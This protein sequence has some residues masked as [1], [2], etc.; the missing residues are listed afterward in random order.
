[1]TRHEY[2]V[3]PAPSRADKIKGARTPAD[4]FSA[5]L[6]QVLNDMAREGWDYVRA[7][8]LPSEERSGLTSR[9]TVWNNV[10]I[11]RRALHVEAAVATEAEEPA[12]PRA[13]QPRPA[14]A[15]APAVNPPPVT[16]PAAPPTAPVAPAIRDTA[17]VATPTATPAGAA[18]ASANP[19]SEPM[20]AIAPEGEGS[21]G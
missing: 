12:P 16:A 18:A 13:A 20:R 4:R 7:E 21:R 3:I 2:T 14:A 5:T 15:H 8:T 9:N 11:F 6:A 1:M 10:L 17:P 19:F